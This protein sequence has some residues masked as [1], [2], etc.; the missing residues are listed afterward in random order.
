MLETRSVAGVCDEANSAATDAPQAAQQPSPGAV[1]TGIGD[2]ERNRP[3]ELRN[4]AP[5]PSDDG[6][7]MEFAGT[8]AGFAKAPAE[9]AELVLAAV[10]EDRFWI[11]T[12]ERYREP[13]RDR[14][15]AIEERTAP[16]A[17]GLILAPYLE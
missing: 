14:H 13:I 9:V 16:P 5:A 17:R 8:F 7:L 1:A 11:E 15:R 4:E 2:S 12:D 6:A 3:K 10:V